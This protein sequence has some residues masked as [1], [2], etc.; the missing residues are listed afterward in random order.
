M[1]SLA[2]GAHALSANILGV[3]SAAFALPLASCG[4]AETDVAVVTVPTSSAASPTLTAASAATSLA[5]PP[6]DPSELAYKTREGVLCMPH[7]L[8]SRDDASRAVRSCGPSPGDWVWTS[9]WQCGGCS[10][11]LDE[12]VTA[13]ERMSTLG[14]CCYSQRY[15]PKHLGR[16]LRAARS[17]E[18]RDAELTDRFADA[19]VA[20]AGAGPGWSS[21]STGGLDVDDPADAAVGARALLLARH[22]EAA[23]LEHAS[24]A[25]FARVAL[26]LMA[27]GAPLSLVARAN[28]AAVD[29][30]RHAVLFFSL[31]SELAGEALGPGELALGRAGPAPGERLELFRRTVED[32]CVGETIAALEARAAAIEAASAG[33]LSPGVCASLAA[34]ADDEARHAELAYATAAWLVD[35]A[36]GAERTAMSSVVERTLAG[37]FEADLEGLQG[38]SAGV[39][40]G[41]PL[42]LGRGHLD[43]RTRAEVARVGSRT[44]VRPAL[45]VLAERLR[46][47]RAE[48][49]HA[50]HG[51]H[52]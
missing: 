37:L 47:P 13:R 32:G 12:V 29:E 46:E 36:R 41:A 25:E 18:P 43:E 28:A 51:A 45:A 7:D 10:Y 38:P 39:D 14:T 5:R 1:I 49:V 17:L 27:V 16:P 3:L 8:T 24:V 50:T 34:L 4:S 15:Y 19:V 52:A 42:P 40:E 9:K 23:A 21:G 33:V 48:R 26:G 22:L 6:K 44:I 31:A 11:G 2:R 20:P 30:V 35:A